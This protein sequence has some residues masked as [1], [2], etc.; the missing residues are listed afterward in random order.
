MSKYYCLIAGLPSISPD[1]TKLNGSVYE[2]KNELELVLSTKDRKIM[3]W[4]YLKFDNRN[5]LSYIRNTIEERFDERGNFS[6]TDIKELYTL[7]K[8]EDRIPEN[9]AAPAYLATFIRNFLERVEDDKSAEARLLEDQLAALYY[10]EAM[11]CG[12]KFLSSWFEMNLNIG[13]MMSV[14]NCRKYGLDKESYILGENEIAEMLRQSNTRDFNSGESTDYM[15]ELL[16][17]VEIDDLMM[18]EKR[19]DMLRWKWLDENTFFKTF[20]IESVITYMLRLE[21]IERWVVLDKA[22]GEKTFRQLVSAMKQESVDTLEEF[23]EKNK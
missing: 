13:N 1:D 7:L 20:D 11:K 23:K 14:L 6:K 5:I 8:E 12:N 4:F 19:L 22:G 2:F 21:M 16:Q 17:I 15:S 10:E 9:S 3:S 18:R